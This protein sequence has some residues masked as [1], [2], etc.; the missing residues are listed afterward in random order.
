M[1]YVTQLMGRGL[2]FALFQS[3]EGGGGE[4]ESKNKIV[5]PIY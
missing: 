4:R 2:S 1:N 3:I 5:I